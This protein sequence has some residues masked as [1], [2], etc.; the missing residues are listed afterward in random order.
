MN[1]HHHHHQHHQPAIIS[2]DRFQ[3]PCIPSPREPVAKHQREIARQMVGSLDTTNIGPAHRIARRKRL[4]DIG[5]NSQGFR[6]FF[7]QETFFGA[8]KPKNSLRIRVCVTKLF[9][10]DKK[11]LSIRVSSDIFPSNRYH[12]IRVRQILVIMQNDRQQDK[13]QNL[14]NIDVRDT[15]SACIYRLLFTFYLE[16]VLHSIADQ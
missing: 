14:D 9:W 15:T 16:P 10:C 12:Q 6:V 1:F 2:T 7:K 3:I 11:S 4:V 13:S 8:G 5:G